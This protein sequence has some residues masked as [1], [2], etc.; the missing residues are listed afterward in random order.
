[1]DDLIREACYRAIKTSLGKDE[2][3]ILISTFYA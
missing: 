3:P 2:L 1:M